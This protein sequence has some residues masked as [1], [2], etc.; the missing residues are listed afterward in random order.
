MSGNPRMTMPTQLVLRAL[1]ADPTAELYGS[2][3]GEAAG[4]MS[5]TVHPILARLEAVEWVESRWE[6]VDP[7][8]AG[9]PARR[10]YRITGAGVEQARAELARVLRPQPGRLAPRPQPGQ[11]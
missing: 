5:G 1:L 7:Q 2:Q 4:L 6:D 10:Y 11:A 3:I 9:R 8:V